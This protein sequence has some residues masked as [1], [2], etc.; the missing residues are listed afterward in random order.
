MGAYE[1]F[2]QRHNG[3]HDMGFVDARI[4]TDEMLAAIERQRILAECFGPLTI[5]EYQGRFNAVMRD[6]DLDRDAVW[7][8]ATRREAIE[9]VYWEFV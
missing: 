4:S 8:G 1:D 9:R 2:E 5:T 3:P 7:E 6:T